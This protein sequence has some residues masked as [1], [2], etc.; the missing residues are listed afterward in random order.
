MVYIAYVASNVNISFGGVF[1]YLFLLSLD[2]DMNTLIFS[3]SSLP[4]PFRPGWDGPSLPFPTLV[5]L[6]FLV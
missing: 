6:V 4:S 2:L 1:V 5:S 3:F